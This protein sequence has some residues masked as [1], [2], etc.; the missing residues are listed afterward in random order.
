MQ[1]N[2]ISLIGDTSSRTVTRTIEETNASTYADLASSDGR[3]ELKLLRN[4][5]TVSGEFRG[6][7][8]T[9]AKISWFVPVGNSSGTGDLIAPI[10]V[11]TVVSAP[12]GVTAEQ[13]TEI[14]SLMYEFENQPAGNLLRA[15]HPQ[16]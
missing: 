8:R 3:F 12:V 7:N 15:A 9:T 10:I 2:T 5:P 13:L 6:V 11:E 16:V 4:I 1:A 14:R